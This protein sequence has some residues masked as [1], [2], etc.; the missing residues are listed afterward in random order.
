LITIII[1]HHHHHHLS[2]I[3]IVVVVVV[4]VIVIVVIIIIIIIKSCENMSIRKVPVEHSSTM[5]SPR[6]VLVPCEAEVLGG[7]P[8]EATQP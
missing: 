6:A 5:T 1:N 7:P 8:K 2:S 3:I 4:V